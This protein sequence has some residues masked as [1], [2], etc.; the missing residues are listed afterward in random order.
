VALI[1]QVLI[2]DPAVDAKSYNPIAPGAKAAGAG[3][4]RESTVG[5]DNRSAVLG[6]IAASSAVTAVATGAVGPAVAFGF[7]LV[8]L[9]GVVTAMAAIRGP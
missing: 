5:G 8:M 3:A 4:E 2:D 1:M 7:F 6:I 9:G